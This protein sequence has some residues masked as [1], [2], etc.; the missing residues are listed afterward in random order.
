M[1]MYM[2]GSLEDRDLRSP[3]TGVT[4]YY[5]LLDVGARR[6]TRVLWKKNIYFPNF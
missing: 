5:K 3:G 6:K 1:Y 2:P 4:G